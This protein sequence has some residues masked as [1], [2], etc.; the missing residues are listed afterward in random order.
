MNWADFLAL[1]DRYTTNPAALYNPIGHYRGLIRL[2]K[3]EAIAALR[4]SARVSLEVKETT[5][6][7]KCDRS[8][9]LASGEFCDCT[10]GR[11]LAKRARWDR[12]KTGRDKAG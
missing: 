10:M 1:D 9:I 11:D 4:E 6:C 5:R 12:E 7:T 3:R 8:G 2:Q